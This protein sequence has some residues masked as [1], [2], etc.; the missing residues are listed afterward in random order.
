MERGDDPND[1]VLTDSQPANLNDLQ[2]N[3]AT[4]LG[5][6]NRQWRGSVTC[7]RFCSDWISHHSRLET[8]P[9]YMSANGGR[10][11]DEGKQQILGQLGERTRGLNMRV[12]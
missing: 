5:C 12:A 11:R 10:V 4:H 8:G 2:T 7:S 1:T 9:I 3:T 6:W